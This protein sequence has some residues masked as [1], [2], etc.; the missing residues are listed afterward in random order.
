MSSLSNPP[1]VSMCQLTICCCIPPFIHPPRRNPKEPRYRSRYSRNI[2]NCS[3]STGQT[4]LP[5]SANGLESSSCGRHVAGC[6][7]TFVRASYRGTF[8][9]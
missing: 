8:I 1:F 6:C 3:L 5:K 4:S 2:R 9:L 7:R